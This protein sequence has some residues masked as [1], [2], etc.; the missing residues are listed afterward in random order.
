LSAILHLL[1]VLQSDTMTELARLAAGALVAG[2][3]QGMFL[4]AGAGLILKFMPKSTATLR[5]VVWAAV[6]GVSVAMPFMNLPG[7]AVTGGVKAATASHVMLD[8]HWSYLLAGLW[9]AIALFRLVQ[10]AMQGYG[11]L[12]LWKAAEPV[13][14]EVLDSL[15]M[16][17]AVHGRMVQLCTSDDVDRPSVIGFFAPKIL[18][19]SWLFQQLTSVELNHIVLHELEHL[20]RRDDWINLAQ[21]IGLVLL[22]LNPALFWLDRRLSTERELACD[23]GVLERTKMPKAYAASL[24]SIEE[25]RL[26]V[27]QHGRFGALALAAT[28]LRRHRSELA[29]R[30][31]SILGRRTP[32]NRGFAVTVAAIF[33]ACVL[34]AG[35]GLSHAP[36]LVSFGPQAV[37]QQATIRT[38]PFWPRV[39]SQD[40]R[41]NEATSVAQFQNVSFREPV[42][43]RTKAVKTA[44]KL[45]PTATVRQ[46]PQDPVTPR[47]QQFVVLTSWEDSPISRVVVQTPDG[48]FLLAP[49]AAVPTQTGWLLVQL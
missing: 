3:W 29:E 14:L 6:F 13:A 21:K 16:K 27:R 10:L 24:A 32:V 44:R 28:G 35:A 47:R 36:Q 45:T 25:R 38:A 20:R 39:A 1:T 17:L 37:S 11:L 15:D 40:I 7:A 34:V 41:T 46:A 4:C 31:E 12:A 18:I 49:Y 30:I 9:L 5:F 43:S 22:P 33:V 26:D 2:L 42:K 8:P 23:D 48:R 19:P